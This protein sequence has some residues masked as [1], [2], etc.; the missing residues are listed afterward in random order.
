MDADPQKATAEDVQALKEILKAQLAR[1]ERKLNGQWPAIPSDAAYSYEEAAVRLKTGRNPH[2]MEETEYER[3]VRLAEADG[4]TK[5]K[6]ADLARDDTNPHLRRLKIGRQP[7]ITEAEI[8]KYLRAL[9]QDAV[10]AHHRL[11]STKT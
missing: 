11:N 9:R 5:R 1:I 6:V 4:I 8:Q 10:K 7:V 3:A 2:E